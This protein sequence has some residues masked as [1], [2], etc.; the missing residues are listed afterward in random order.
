M[1]N[2]PRMVHAAKRARTPMGHTDAAAQRDTS[3]SLT[4][5]PAKP[6]KVSATLPRQSTIIRTSVC[7]LIINS[8]V[9]H[10]QRGIP[11]RRSL[12]LEGQ[13]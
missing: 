13:D 11:A 8:T 3:C 4:G 9:L 10:S 2:V 12:E 7:L 1:M 5:D 6:N